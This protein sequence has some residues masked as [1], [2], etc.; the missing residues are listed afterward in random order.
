MAQ[1]STSKCS[2]CGVNNGIYFCYECRKALCRS[3][4]TPHDNI[5]ASKNHTVTDLKSVDRT[6][7]QNLSNCTVHNI[8]FTLYCTQC[9]V[10][11]C[12]KCVT[13]H[14]RH[15]ISHIDQIVDEMRK[16]AEIQVE[17][18]GEKLSKSSM[19]MSRVE[20]ENLP[21][22]ENQAKFIS[23][24][25]E[26]ARKDIHHVINSIADVKITEIEDFKTLEK[27]Q[28]KLN[29]AKRKQIHF[30]CSNLHSS[31]QQLLNEKHAI[32]FLNAY[33]N[34]K[35]DFMEFQDVELGSIEVKQQPHFD[36][37]L[38]IEDIT[39][40]LN[41][42]QLQKRTSTKSPKHDTIKESKTKLSSV[43]KPPGR[44]KQTRKKDRSTF[45]RNNSDEYQESLEFIF[46]APSP[47]K[48]EEEWFSKIGQLIHK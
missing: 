7:F 28:L 34:L 10:T 31:L 4:R 47:E 46:T 26:V 1:K 32:T 33:Q 8:D 3:C 13:K 15:D 5:P 37:T 20:K 17:K 24:E 44:L 29:L 2:L 6:A 18:M 22:I 36:K 21:E 9:K 14:N 45:Q 19:I 16:E 48:L 38:F 41:T 42:T 12:G 27:D 43:P 23:N 11:I 39:Q 35:G 40:T 25:I 30:R